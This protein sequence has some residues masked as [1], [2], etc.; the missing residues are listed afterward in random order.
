MLDVFL[1]IKRWFSVEAEKHLAP[2]DTLSFTLSSLQEMKQSLEQFTEEAAVRAWNAVFLSRIQRCAVILYSS[3]SSHICTFLCSAPAEAGRG[4]DAG[5]QTSV[6]FHITG[7]KA[8]HELCP[9]ASTHTQ[10]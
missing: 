8:A 9:S 1:Q 6:C 3:S 5:P 4:V 10:D 2:L 7:A